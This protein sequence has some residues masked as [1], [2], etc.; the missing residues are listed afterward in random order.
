MLITAAAET[1]GVDRSECRA[2]RGEVHHTGG[3]RRISYG[4]LVERAA[5]VAVPQDVPLKDAADWKLIGTRVPR[6]DT[7]IKV[8]GG[9]QFGIDVRVPGMLVAT[10]ARCPVIGGTVARFTDEAA[11]AVPGVRHVAR[12]SSGIAVIAD[13]FWPAKRGRDALDIT[14]DEGRNA[15][16]SSASI[17]AQ[18]ER[19]RDGAG[20]S[21][22]RDGD[23]S[24]GLRN[25]ARRVEAL[26]DTPFLAHA[27]GRSARLPTIG[28]N[29][30]IEIAV[31]IATG[32]GRVDVHGASRATSG[33]HA[34]A[35]W[36]PHGDRSAS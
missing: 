11:R 26:Y 3:R 33:R 19:L 2:E 21:A 32:I 17:A 8:D 36:S 28:A 15:S 20:I 24:A 22:R 13:G 7:P 23:P 6:L 27:G 34:I 12:V 30:V 35:H 10:I 16:T 25:A 29:P 31:V 5:L 4:Q 9:A 1:W 14:W 18:L